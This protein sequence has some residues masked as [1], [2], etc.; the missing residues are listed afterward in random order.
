[1]NWLKDKIE[2]QVCVHGVW[3]AAGS[4]VA[5]ELAAAAGFDWVLLDMEHGLGGEAD[6]L[7]MIQALSGTGAAPVVRVPSAASEAIPRVLDYG[8]AGIMAPHIATA[9][10]AAAFVRLLRYPPA[11]SRGLTASSRASGYGHGFAEYFRQA[12]AR[13]AGIVQ[14]ETPQ[15]VAQAD[16]IAATDGVDVLFIGHS[17]LSLALGCF[18]DLAAPVMQAAE[19]AVLDACARHG[20]RAGM[21]FK[22][23]MA[24]APYRR[25]GFSVLALGSDIGCLKQGFDRFLADA[26]E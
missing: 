21:L 6:I 11:G 17:D 23:G 24:V 22:A 26:R 10:E 2:R 19:T 15:A 14:V 9:G 5:A 7:R 3:L 20:K 18:G 4:H 8:A 13:V 12:N 1:M 16:A 25:R